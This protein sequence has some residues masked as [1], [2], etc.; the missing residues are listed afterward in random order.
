MAV[1]SPLPLKGNVFISV[2]DRDKPEVVE[3]ARTFVELGFSVYAT[4]GT[5]RVISESGVEVKKLPKLA[6]GRPNVLDFIKNHDMHFVVN[7]PDDRHTRADEVRI[8]SG[9]VANRIPIMT[10]MSSARASLEAIRSLQQR[11]LTVK[12]LQEYHL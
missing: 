9:A 12:P 3:L 1:S 11:E 7:V 5:G 10:N 2:R 6:E 8:R 4:S